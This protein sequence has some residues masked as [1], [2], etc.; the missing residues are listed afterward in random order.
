MLEL[1]AQPSFVSDPLLQN[2]QDVWV[3]DAPSLGRPALRGTCGPLCHTWV[4][5]QHHSSAV[6]PT[7]QCAT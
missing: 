3:P 2:Q 4:Q 6:T 7:L 5:L 1:I